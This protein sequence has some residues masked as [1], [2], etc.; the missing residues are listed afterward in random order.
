[1]SQTNEAT[2][3]AEI[4]SLQQ[5]VVELE[6]ALAR[7]ETYLEIFHTITLDLMN[8]LDVV[9]LL[10][11]IL[12]RAAELLNT[13][14]GYLYLVSPAGDEL[15]N[16]IATGQFQKYTGCRLKFGE[17]LAGKTWASG[18]PLV[19]ADYHTWAGRSLQHESD[20]FGCVATM[21][22]I[23][24][25]G[26]V[27]GVIGMAYPP[28]TQ[29]FDAA[30]M[31]LLRRFAQLSSLALENAKVYAAAKDEL[32]ERQRLE[33]EL[34]ESLVEA[35]QTSVLLRSII[36]NSPDMIFM[37]NSE[38]RYTLT[39]QT[40]AEFLGKSLAEIIGYND[41][42]IGFST[43]EVFGN[44]ARELRGF[45]ADDLEV[46]EHGQAIRNTSNGAFRADGQWRILDTRKIPLRD[47]TG[48][49]IGLL[50]VNHDITELKTTQE[51][52]RQNERFLHTVLDGLP[53]LIAF[54]GADNRYRFVNTAFVK[55]TGRK[56]EEIEGCNFTPLLDEP[57]PQKVQ[58]MVAK[59]LAGHQLTVE[60]TSVL[61]DGQ[62]RYLNI[63]YL[64]VHNKENAVEGIVLAANDITHLKEAEA[65][66]AKLQAQVVET[67]REF[68]RELSSP[69]IPLAN[70][71]V[72]MPLIGKIDSNRVQQIMETLLEGV[73]NYEAEVAILDITGVPVV[74][75]QIAHAL[76]QAAQAVRLLGSHVVLTGIQPSI[77]QILVELGI[78]L[79]TLTTYSSL[80]KGI[81]YALQHVANGNKQRVA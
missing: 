55:W 12:Q 25:A 46:F 9:D 10:E 58:E 63:N 57:N 52:L 22:L 70:G 48:Q 31:E 32:A 40:M 54:V 38:F 42:E 67:Q 74:D 49:I 17:G 73:T 6:Q 34:E 35:Q 8:K 15:E 78:D 81:A 62:V 7:Q 21:P 1:M 50:G 16:K 72:V 65:E 41:L 13:P 36:D 64:P 80:Q 33:A 66:Q 61:P 44:P 47:A 19:I 75:E 43:E 11:E 2:S 68:I 5:R 18:Q 59:A 51:A 37:K 56:R 79:R 69:L 20:S 60:T 53:W 71:V 28:K 4:S 29:A 26:K 23:S 77:A 39:N 30:A 24:A 45:R 3:Q 14:H 76:L 27:V